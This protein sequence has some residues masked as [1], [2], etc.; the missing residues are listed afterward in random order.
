MPFWL[1]VFLWLDE[2]LSL[3]L[4]SIILMEARLGDLRLEDLRLL[5]LDFFDL[6]FLFLEAVAFLTG[7]AIILAAFFLPRAS[8]FAAYSFIF[9]TLDIP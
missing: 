7:F 5:D 4:F 9:F 6:D 1:F 3:Y 2:C 8:I